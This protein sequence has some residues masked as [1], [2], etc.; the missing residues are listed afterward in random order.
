MVSVHPEMLD[1]GSG[2]GRSILQLPSFQE[3]NKA[4]LRQNNYH[5]NIW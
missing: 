1:L 4:G 3:R 2:Q 5:L